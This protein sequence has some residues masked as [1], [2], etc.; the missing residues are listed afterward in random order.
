MRTLVSVIFLLLIVALGVCAALARRSRRADGKPVALLL[1]S[2][3]V[4]VIGNLILV[5]TGVRAVALAGYYVYFLGMDLTVFALLP[6]APFGPPAGGHRL[7]AAGGPVFLRYRGPVHL[8]E[9]RRD[10]PGRGEGGE[11]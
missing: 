8:G 11:L 4:P 5:L 2:L 3:I 10:S 9:S 7:G 1:L 6:P